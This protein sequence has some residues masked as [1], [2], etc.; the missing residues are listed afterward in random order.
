MEC[1]RLALA[2]TEFW[3]FWFR[4]ARGGKG[5]AVRRE[6]AIGQGQISPSHHRMLGHDIEDQRTLGLLRC[7]TKSMGSSGKKAFEVLATWLIACE[8]ISHFI[9]K[10]S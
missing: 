1:R 10:N 5:S 8:I 7:Y 2:R 3:N 6:S 4:L 9:L